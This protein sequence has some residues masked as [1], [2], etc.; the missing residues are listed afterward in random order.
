MLLPIGYFIT[1]QVFYYPPCISSN[2]ECNPIRYIILI[3]ILSL[4]GHL[5][6]HRASHHSMG[7]LSPIGHIILSS[8]LSPQECHL[9]TSYHLLGMSSH[10][11]SYLLTGMLSPIGH[12]ITY[13]ISHPIRHIITRLE[14][15]LTRYVILMG[16]SFH[17]I[18]HHPPIILSYQAYQKRPG[19]RQCRALPNKVQ[20]TNQSWCDALPN[21]AQLVSMW[22]FA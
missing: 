2:W 4:I 10:Q 5:I 7:I 1:H 19:W 17:W 16:I 14:Y 22:S 8:I 3:G 6:S 13:Q 20:L 9:Q 15:H 11:K 18:S 12:L 21:K